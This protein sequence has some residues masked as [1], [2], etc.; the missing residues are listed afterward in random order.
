MEAVRSIRE[1]QH[2]SISMLQ[3]R[4]DY[5]YAIFI[6]GIVHGFG[7]SHADFLLI[8]AGLTRAARISWQVSFT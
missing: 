8:Y 1:D 5:M 2:K 3:I 4:M 7:A 6:C